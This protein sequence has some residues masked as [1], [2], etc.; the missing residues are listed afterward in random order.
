VSEYITNNTISIAVG[1]FDSTNVGETI[2]NQTKFFDSKN[3]KNRNLLWSLLLGAILPI[4]FWL[5]GRRWKWCHL[6]HIPL[7][8]TFISWM[9][10][11]SAG[12]L[13]TWLLIGVLTTFFFDNLYWKR[14]VYLTTSALNAGYF[15]CWLIIGGPLAHYDVKFPSW[16]GFGGIHK[17]GCPLTLL[18]TTGFSPS[19]QN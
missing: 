19:F 10:I 7:M 16:W 11:V 14:H 18:N 5:A 17:D 12:S 6:V 8:L 15:L 1:S 9:P 2:D 4:P 13:F 3:W